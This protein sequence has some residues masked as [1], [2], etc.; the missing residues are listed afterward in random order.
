MTTSS[1]AP[2]GRANGCCFPGDANL[3]AS[4]AFVATTIATSSLAFAAV[5]TTSSAFVATIEATSSLVFIIVSLAFVVLETTS[6]ALVAT[7]SNFLTVS[8]ASSAATNAFLAS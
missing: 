8:T 2:A 3:A 7:L 5:A 6:S 1:A 4:S